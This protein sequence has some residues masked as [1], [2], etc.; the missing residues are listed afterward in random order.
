MCPGATSVNIIPEFPLPRRMIF[1]QD[2][3]KYSFS[4]VVDFLVTKL[5]VRYTEYLLGD[6]TTA[7]ANPAFIDG[8]MTSNIFE[9]K[10]DNVRVALPQ[11]AIAAASYCQL[12][13]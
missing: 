10:R 8:P 9:A 13:E 2:S 7:L 11:A 12:Q 1:K 5:P 3:G 6:P 4:G